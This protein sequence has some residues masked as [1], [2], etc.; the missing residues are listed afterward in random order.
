ML[1]I[2]L[3][4]KTLTT[5]LA[6]CRMPC[7]RSFKHRARMAAT[8]SHPT[9]LP[10]T[11]RRSMSARH[12]KISSYCTW[13]PSTRSLIG[14]WTR[15][16]QAPLHS[17]KR[18]AIIK[19]QPFALKSRC[20]TRIISRADPRA[21]R[22]MASE[23][24]MHRILPATA[25]QAIIRRAITSKRRESLRRVQRR[26]LLQLK[27]PCATLRFTCLALLTMRAFLDQH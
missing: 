17:Q 18:T 8:H 6:H 15:W 12:A 2:L 21:L 27:Q 20:L 9:T 1:L 5:S 16:R 14:Q 10:M 23:T 25:Q 26:P 4:K 19:E 13:T 22:P 11:F 24:L 7:Y 3:S